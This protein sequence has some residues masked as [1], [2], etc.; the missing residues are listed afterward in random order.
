[1]SYVCDRKRAVVWGVDGGLPS[2]PHG[3][4]IKRAVS[5]T[6][7]WPGSVF[8]DFPMYSGDEFARPTAGGGGFR[9]PLERTTDMVL[10]DVV[11]GYVS[12]GRAALDYG[13][14][15]N[16]VDVDLCEYEVDEAATDKLRAY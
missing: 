10:A 15:I 4:T 14:V 3:L 1:M 8:F 16:E 2:M 13:V 11:E 5:D 7:E 12:I 6:S 9:D